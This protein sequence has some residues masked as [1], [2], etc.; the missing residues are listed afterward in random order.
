MS[1]VAAT[2]RDVAPVRW[3]FLGA[4][5]IAT[6]ALAPAI[7]R[8]RVSVLHSVGARDIGRAR[9][10]G[11]VGEAYDS[12]RAVIEDPEVEAVYI[13]LAN[14]VHVQW[15][16]EALR[17]GKHVLCEKP[18]GMS[19]AEVE[20]LIAAADETGLLAVEASWNRWH[21][22]TVR[23]AE[24][25]ASEE[26]GAVRHVSTGFTF[27]GV[28]ADNYRLDP[29]HGGGALYDL[30]PYAMAAPLWLT[31]WSDFT[32]QRVERLLHPGGVDLTTRAWMRVGDVD[33]FCVTAMNIPDSEWLA[34]TGEDGTAWLPG[35]DAF[36]SRDTP[37]LLEVVGRD[38]R[39][40]EEFAPVDPYQRM[41]DAVSR[42]IRGA[43]DWVMPLVESLAFA[44][45]FDHLRSA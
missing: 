34:V 38:G 29:A 10:L 39:R 32:A 27:N 25:I 19:A 42:R 12:Y 16:L 43:D 35:G 1:L 45:L 6:R 13:A 37:S 40:T 15:S 4:G 5:W 24:I 41:L 2:V 30:G 31:G 28:E 11:P 20:T 14:D 26:I 3:G 36:T 17:A 23:L 8:S 22:R 18:L 9:A 33:A 44:R 7:H 21:P